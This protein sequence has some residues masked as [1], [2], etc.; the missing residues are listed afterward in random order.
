MPIEAATTKIELHIYTLR[1]LLQNSLF[2]YIDS[3][4]VKHVY[5][6]SK[7]TKK[8]PFKNTLKQWFVPCRKWHHN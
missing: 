4:K 6:H 7:H 3:L 1:L 2:S 8:S 5:K